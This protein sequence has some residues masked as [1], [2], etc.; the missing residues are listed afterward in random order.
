MRNYVPQPWLALHFLKSILHP[1][2]HVLKRTSHPGGL[3]HCGWRWT[4]ALFLSEPIPLGKIHA[5]ACWHYRIWMCC[6]TSDWSFC[7]PAGFQS[8]PV[9]WG[10][11]FGN[12]FASREPGGE[13]QTLPWET[14]ALG[15]LASHLCNDPSPKCQEVAQPKPTGA[16]CSPT[17]S[18]G[19]GEIDIWKNKHRGKG[20]AEF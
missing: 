18:P 5:I 14:T 20:F 17:S 9:G 12:C 16:Q 13:K 10:P 3:R 19:E 6:I 15:H 4:G 7:A 8:V 11:R 2:H 1:W